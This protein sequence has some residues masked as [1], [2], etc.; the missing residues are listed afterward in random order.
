M[1]WE[2]E[3]VKEEEEGE[4]SIRTISLRSARRPHS[5]TLLQPLRRTRRPASPTP[6]RKA[7]RLTTFPRSAALMASIL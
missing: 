6:A 7:S 3:E 1:E 2:E 5:R 4:S